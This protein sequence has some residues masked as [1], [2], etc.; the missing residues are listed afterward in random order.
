MNSQQEHEQI[1]LEKL[2]EP[3]SWKNMKKQT[4]LAIDPAPIDRETD[5]TPTNTE[6]NNTL[7]CKFPPIDIAF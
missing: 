3:S 1:V 2:R 4:R 7:T 5:N 6:T